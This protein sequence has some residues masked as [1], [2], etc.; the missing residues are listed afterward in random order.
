[1]TKKIRKK[2]MILLVLLIFAFIATNMWAAG[3]KDEAK[4]AEGTEM[5]KLSLTKLDGTKVEK[6]VEKPRYGGV[7]TGIFPRDFTGFDE[8]LWPDGCHYWVNHL[9][10]EE[11]IVGDWSRG[12]SGTNEA[13]WLLQGTT[14]MDLSAGIV[15]ESWEIAD[16]VTI[17]F[18]IRKGIYWHDKP[19]VN[20]RELTAHD[21][22][23]TVDRIF[24][25][26][27][28]YAHTLKSSYSSAT[29]TDKYT[30][31]L[32]STEG[33]VGTLF[34]QVVDYM[35]IV[36]PE[37]I[38][39]YGSVTEWEQVV[40]TGPF[41]VTDHVPGSTVTLERNPNYWG[42]D[43]L[44]PENQLP[45]LD[46]V[47]YLTITDVSTQTAALRTA[48]VDWMLQ[49][50]W[51]AK[52]NLVESNPELKT[53]EYLR[54][55]HPGVIFWRLD[56]PELPFHDIRVRRALAMAID[57][58]AIKE[59]F[60]GGNAEIF[61]VPVAPYPELMQYFTP[62]EEQS[63]IVQE[64]YGYHPEKAKELLAE[65]GY[66]N[67]FKTEMVT[68]P[69]DVD[70]LSIVKEDWAKIGVELELDVRERSVYRS[71]MVGRAHNEMAF[72]GLSTAAPKVFGAFR[73]DKVNNT[74]MVDD[75]RTNEA[76]QAI[77][78]NV[79][80]N[81]PE[82]TRIL[83]EIYPYTLDQA[84][85]MELPSFYEYIVWWP[86]VKGYNGEWTVGRC[87]SYAF[88]MYIWYD[89]DLKEEMVGRR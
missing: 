81:E 74:S 70:L 41:I 56:K 32:K 75:P 23:F 73:P 44:H 88:P 19:P 86:W 36:A 48:K 1:M 63:E 87:N 71:I 2:R 20:G 34:D 55:G 21:V 58:E 68:L 9:T 26:P 49:V 43:P 33:K 85:F 60:Y 28:S 42:T 37:V 38:E 59:Q 66:A 17:I 30:V 31:V 18:N 52:A 45:Y 79:T 82:V 5:V 78:K 67:G 25:S 3:Q 22:A 27:R 13:S 69:T 47:E 83:K 89:Q 62:L 46:G 54:A 11:L 77:Q 84:W 29:A 57:K 24:N 50:D 76:W 12:P 7:F 64:Y 53:K 15:A 8:A 14:F 39:K 61:S 72:A 65:A 40:G 80:V 6:T 16:D 51:E 10:N 35:M 4:T